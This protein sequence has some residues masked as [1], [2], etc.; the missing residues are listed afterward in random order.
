M[1]VADVVP[2][3]TNHVV[4]IV[5]DLVVV[6]VVILDTE[7]VAASVIYHV[8]VSAQLPMLPYL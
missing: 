3:K 1:L 4:T 8:D 5:V 7:L 6:L 2:V